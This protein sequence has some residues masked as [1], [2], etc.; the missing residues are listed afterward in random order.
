MR[1]GLFVVL[2]VVAFVGFE[3]NMVL[4]KGI[5]QAEAGQSREGMHVLDANDTLTDVA[6]LYEPLV[7]DAGGSLL[8]QSQPGLKVR[9][10]RQLLAQALANLIDNAMKYGGDRNGDPPKLYIQGT[11][12][13]KFVVLEVADKGVGIAES[14]RERVRDRFVRLD[15]SRTKPGNGLGLS[16]VSSLMTLHGG[17][18]LLEDNMPGL[19]AILRLPLCSEAI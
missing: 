14:D 17:Q 19:R 8:L 4:A 18:L 16:L 2:A 1:K 13:G 12:Q 6:E 15:E 10:D 7:E 3:A 11:I 5:A 9:G